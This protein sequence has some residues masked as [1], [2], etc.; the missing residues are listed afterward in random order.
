MRLLEIE[1][2]GRGGLTH[3]VFNL[4]RALGRRGVTVRMVTAAEYELDGAQFELPGTVRV[5]RVYGRLT[6]RLNPPVRWRRWLR[7]VEFL[8]DSV[9]VLRLVLKWRPQVVHI[10]SAHPIVA[11]QMLLLRVFGQRM[12]L[13]AHDVTLHQDHRLL[14]PI[15]KMIYRLPDHIVVHGEASRDQLCDDLGVD[16]KRVSIMPHG[17]Y[18]FFISGDAEPSR[19]EARARLRLDS[20]DEVILIFGFLREHKGLEDQLDVWSEIVGERPAAR[21]VIAGDPSGLAARKRDQVLNR[22][23]SM[24]AVCHLRY[25]PFGEVSTFFAAADLM[26]LPYRTIT[27]SGVLHLAQ[28]LEVPVVA[29]SVGALPEAISDGVTGIL[30]PP[31][32]PTELTAAIARLL[33]DPEL[34][35]HLAHA[36]RERVIE[37][38]S[39]ETIA[40]RT[41]ALCQRVVSPSLAESGS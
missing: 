14:G 1:I 8:P 40:E 25:I 34:R 31:G 5:D 4:S 6:H 19:E 39:W 18:A 28:S 7:G 15:Y 23:K 35:A 21:L 41:E 29:S 26:V 2:F 3:Y 36:A 22:A 12:V 20:D 10:H 17:E 38:G 13:T 32:S 37:D 30:V 11:W 33:G 24:G 27:Q 16:E 9:A